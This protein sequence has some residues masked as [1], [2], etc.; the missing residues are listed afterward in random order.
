M[1]GGGVGNGGSA[2]REIHMK[3]GAYVCRGCLWLW[4]PG[5]SKGRAEQILNIPSSLWGNQC[6]QCPKDAHFNCSLIGRQSPFMKENVPLNM[7][8]V[9]LTLSTVQRKKNSQG[10]KMQNIEINS[11]SLK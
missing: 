3:Q 9:T 6:L 5:G 2:F 11:L 4:V 1:A 8:S 10:H 7:T